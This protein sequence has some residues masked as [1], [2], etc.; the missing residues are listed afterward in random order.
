MT[1]AFVI[2]ELA[3]Q[4]RGSTIQ[5][6]DAAENEWLTW[7]PEGTSNHLLW[8]AGHS[9]W[10]QG[11]ICLEPLIGDSELPAKWAEVFG[12][13]CRPVPRTTHWPSR[14]ELRTLLANQLA[15]VL[16][17]VEEAGEARLA[18]V[19][20]ARG[21]TLAGRIIHGI[22]DEARHQG[23]MYLLLKLCRSREGGG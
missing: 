10:L 19:V 14:N 20:N 6:L 8:H 3:R 1:T 2:Q 7:A 16:A 13:N 15:R 21:D 17:V 4:V 9:L 23:E 5:F 22:H 11:V 12:M 18:E